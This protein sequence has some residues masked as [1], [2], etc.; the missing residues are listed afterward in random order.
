LGIAVCLSIG[1]G[2]SL[3]ILSNLVCFRLAALSSTSIV[4]FALLPLSFRLTNLRRY[5]IGD[6]EGFTI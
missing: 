1:V 2:Q 5:V 4:S 6:H 3:Y